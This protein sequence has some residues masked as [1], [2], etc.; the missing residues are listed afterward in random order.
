MGK[1]RGG[2]FHHKPR[3]RVTRIGARGEGAQEEGSE[4]SDDEVPQQRQK[5]GVQIKF[6]A[7]S[8]V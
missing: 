6:D 3:E 5:H 1:S 4:S 2:K 8:L 7:D